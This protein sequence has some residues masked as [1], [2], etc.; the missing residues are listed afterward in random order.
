MSS[1]KT[2]KT[3]KE[4]GKEAS[5]KKTP[6]ATPKG[7]SKPKETPK[8]PIKDSFNFY[9]PANVDKKS[10]GRYGD[11]ISLKDKNG[12]DVDWPK[13]TESLDECL[14]RFGYNELEGYIYDVHKKEFNKII[15]HNINLL[16]IEI[17]FNAG[18]S[19][20]YFLSK[21]SR[22]TVFSFDI[23]LHPYTYVGK[24]YID[25]I[26]Q[27]RHTLE[28][29]D[30]IKSIPRFA[31]VNK[32]LN[33]QADLIFIDGD[34]TY[35]RAYADIFNCYYFA[36]P[37]T[38]LVIDNVIPHRGVGKE[39]YK[40]FKEL[41]NDNMLVFIKHVEVNGKTDT[42]KDGFIIAKYRFANTN[43]VNEE[44]PN[45]EYI[46][47]RLPLYNITNKI[48]I[49]NTIDGLNN[50]RKELDALKAKDK[51]LVDNY[52]YTELDKKIHSIRNPENFHPTKSKPGKKEAAVGETGKERYF[53]G[54]FQGSAS[55]GSAS[56]GYERGRGS[57][58]RGSTSRGSFQGSAS[59]SYERGRGTV[60]QSVPRGP[61]PGS[62]S[63]PEN[64]TNVKSSTPKRV[65]P[66][67]K[68][69][70]PEKSQTQT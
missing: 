57:V 12:K 27:G 26:H 16:I 61:R 35:E 52:A 50:I 5:T 23:G 60:S 70:P 68:E 33:Q 41:Y 32:Q 39:V 58:S 45:W 9:I 67:S 13:S 30:S 37:N 6:K 3:G 1:V 55:R 31:S 51:D 54:S 56:R 14:K 64:P 7:T 59:G 21:F 43:Y 20:N 22:S 47:R 44:I 34:H 11:F 2:N 49:T 18:H 38:I 48:S 24:L 19:S 10:S 63:S 42:Y 46:E 36:N 66:R 29:G 25:T 65:P 4:S 15:N 69:F 17:G 62:V 8:E 53:P 40:A 28:L